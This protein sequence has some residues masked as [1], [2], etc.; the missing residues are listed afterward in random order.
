MIVL[1]ETV[2]GI[3][4]KSVF[5]AAATADSRCEGVKGV[6]RNDLFTQCIVRGRGSGT[7]VTVLVQM[8][9]SW[10]VNFGANA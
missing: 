10:R 2:F 3:K 5:Y 9:R 1:D 4:N 8:Y 7:Y 6:R